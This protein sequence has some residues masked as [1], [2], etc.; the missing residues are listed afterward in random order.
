VSAL[1]GS[2]DLGGGRR[3]AYEVIGDGE[4]LL[5]FQGGPGESATLLRDDAR[6]L[7]DRFAVHLIEPHGSGGS[8]PPADP[9]LYDHIGHA[10][11]YE[12]VRDALDI[13]RATIMGFSF[14]ATVALTYAALYPAATI[15]CI[16]I[17]GRAAGEQT[18]GDE[19]AAEMERALSRHAHAP[20]YGSA[21]KV[22]D[23]WTERVLAARDPAELDAMMAE[24]LPLYTAHPERPGVRALIDKWR[25][26]ARGDLAAAKAWESG[27]WQTL[28]VRPLLPRIHCPTLL[29]VGEL[30]MICGPTQGQLISQA[31]PHAEVLTVSDCGHFIAAEAPAEFRAAVIAFC[32]RHADR[33]SLA[34]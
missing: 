9:S 16:S 17:A 19:S 3:A 20:W 5:F 12:E 21:R 24:V 6:L 29:L 7:S 4:P 18:A 34:P 13:E 14:G 2:V 28:D 1:K 33:G 25:R 15:R 8:T 22:W 32:D 10:R 27:L 11:F 26:E 23:E 31:V 30:D